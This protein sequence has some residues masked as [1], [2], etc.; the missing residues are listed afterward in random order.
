MESRF[1]RDFSPVRVHTDAQAAASAQA[2]H[3]RAFTVGQDVVFGKGQ[4]APGS[5]AGR[6]LLAHELAHTIQQEGMPPD[7]PQLVVQ[8]K[9]LD[10]PSGCIEPSLP[11]GAETP[12][13]SVAEGASEIRGDTTWVLR[14]WD[15]ARDE[16][17]PTIDHLTA[18][19]A[20]FAAAD[21]R[22]A[23]ERN[24]DGWAVVSIVGHASPE[25]EEDHNAE[26]AQRRAEAV[27]G[28]IGGTTA[29]VSRGEACGAGVPREE[30]PY[31]RAV[32]VAIE[33]IQESVPPAV[34]IPEVDPEP[35]KSPGIKI[36]PNKA[37]KDASGAR[38]GIV[39]AVIEIVT[40]DDPAKGPPK[41]GIDFKKGI[42]GG[43][44]G[45]SKG[46]ADV[47]F[48]AN[49]QR[50]FDQQLKDLE[51]EIKAQLASL[52]PAAEQMFMNDP[53]RPVYAI[54]HTVLPKTQISAAETLAE[55]NPGRVRLAEP[56][57]LAREPVSREYENK[58]VIN[59]IPKVTAIEKH[60]IKS[61]EIKMVTE[62]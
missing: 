50:S 54:V 16:A 12:G 33:F 41:L 10:E 57:A 21:L 39:D 48:E 42:E 7:R 30:Y 27:S 25:G 58:K 55:T 40:P 5:T 22:R 44:E 17:V 62:D 31:F 35:R 52:R 19:Q 37:L 34:H 49:T 15:F 6:L 46:L 45:I 8:S 9:P 53:T 20:F 32:D 24:I 43:G 3:A 4:Y 26:L 38:A 18:M 56:I 51:P 1:G 14:L 23:Q 2:V 47:A 13:S 59:G 61:I 60:V 36:D 11:A 28:L 29:P